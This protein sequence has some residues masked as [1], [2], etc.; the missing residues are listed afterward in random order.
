MPANSEAQI[1]RYQNWLRS[2]RGLQFDSYDAL[3]Q[4]SVDDLPAF[5][6]SIWDYFEVE[7]PTPYRQVIAA[8]VMPG[9][10]WFEGAQLNYARQV[11]RHVDKAD[12]TGCPAIVFAD[13]LMLASGTLRE[14]SWPELKRQVAALALALREMGVQRGDRVGAVLANRPETAVA[15]LACASIGAIWSICSPDMG[16]VS[17][18][19]RFRQIE[20]KVL[21]AADGYRWGGQAYDRREVLAELL[22]EL[23]SVEHLILW[24][25]LNLAVPLPELPGRQVHDLAL[26][27]SAS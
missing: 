14:L 10:Q 1:T 24:R 25:H 2:E 4:W 6:G 21:I 8:E 19:D 17:V 12:A 26:L 18:L 3:W 15:F 13:E 27:L 7:S 23:P 20:P 11:L 5:W 16:P 9:A 22:P